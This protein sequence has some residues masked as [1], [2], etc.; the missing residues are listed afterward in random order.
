MK[1][2]ILA[3]IALLCGVVASAGIVISSAGLLVTGGGIALLCVGNHKIKTLVG[4]ADRPVTIS[5]AQ[6]GLGLALAF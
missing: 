2:L 1:K 5:C 4:P 3:V 6:S